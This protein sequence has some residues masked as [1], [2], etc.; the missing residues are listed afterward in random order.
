MKKHYECLIINNGMLSAEDKQAAEKKIDQIFSKFKVKILKKIEWGKRK[1]GYPIKK[2]FHGDYFIFYIEAEPTVIAELR[3]LF[4]YE[5]NV[6]KNMFFGVEDWEKELLFL[7]KL[8]ADPQVNVA[9]L[10]KILEK[11]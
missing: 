4:G 3:T 8:Q 2:I 6:L 11:E 7:N 1:L 10:I 5:T 9:N